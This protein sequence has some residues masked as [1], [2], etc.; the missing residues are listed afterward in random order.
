[1]KIAL[2]GVTGRAGSR[3]ASELLSRGHA[4][5]GIALHVHAMSAKSGFRENRG[6]SQ[7]PT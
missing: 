5:T 6:R 2:I 4:L 7:Y 1:M 3:L